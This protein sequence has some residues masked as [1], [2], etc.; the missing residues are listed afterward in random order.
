MKIVR[1]IIF[2]FIATLYVNATEIKVGNSFSGT[3]VCGDTIGNMTILITNFDDRGN[4]NSATLSATL[5][6]TVGEISGSYKMDGY[7]YKPKSMIRLNPRKWIN[8]PNGFRMIGTEGTL[9]NNEYSGYI[10]YSGKQ[11]STF[12][13]KKFI[14]N[15]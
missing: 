8:K 4:K 10:T 13:T 5:N 2:L 3:Y 9:N 15:K 1:S 11:C 12:S 14:L 6:F 7:L